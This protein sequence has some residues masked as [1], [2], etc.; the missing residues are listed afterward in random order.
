MTDVLA[1]LFLVR[2]AWVLTKGL[3]ILAGGGSRNC[4]GSGVVVK[5]GRFGKK[6][7]RLTKRIRSGK[8]EDI[9]QEINRYTIG[10]ME[11]D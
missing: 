11:Y 4:P 5:H 6:L 7:R 9:I 1:R 2:P 8:Q 10:W 3:K